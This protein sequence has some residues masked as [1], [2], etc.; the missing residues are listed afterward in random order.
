MEKSI[1]L[2]VFHEACEVYGSSCSFA[3]CSSFRDRNPI[4]WLSDAASCE[5]LAEEFSSRFPATANKT[6][7]P[8]DRILA[9]YARRYICGETNRNCEIEFCG[10]AAATRKQMTDSSTNEQQI[11]PKDDEGDSERLLNSTTQA[12]VDSF[13][14]KAALE[15]ER[16]RLV[17]TELA[18]EAKRTVLAEQIKAEYAA[19]VEL[20]SALRRGLV[21]VAV[22]REKNS[23]Q[24]LQGA[25]QEEMEVI[26]RRRQASKQRRNSAAESE[27]DSFGYA[28]SNRGLVGSGRFRV[29]PAVPRQRNRSGFESVNNPP[30]L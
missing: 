17:E 3:L 4:S 13:Q 29:R 14:D 15:A 9:K 27:A 6:S 19:L 30:G 11:V 18:G 2:I 16:D 24:W 22:A 25:N 26:S 5:V 7:T 8:G 12:V 23:L 28:G 20:D 10:T 1:S 21:Q